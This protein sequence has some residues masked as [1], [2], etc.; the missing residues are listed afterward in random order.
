MIKQQFCVRQ[1]L[2]RGQARVRTEWRWLATAFNLDRLQARR[3][4]GPAPANPS[5]PPAPG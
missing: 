1:F 4:A 3:R 2:L 5:L